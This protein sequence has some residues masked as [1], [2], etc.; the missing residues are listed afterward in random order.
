MDADPHV[1]GW[2][3]T[4]ALLAGA[5]VALGAFGAHG[6]EGR[7]TPSRLDVFDTAVRYQ[8]LHALGLLACA[9]LGRRALAAAPWFLAG[10]VL[11][12]G[13]L[14]ALAAGGPGWWGAVA[15]FG[16]AAMIGGWLVLAW[17]AWRPPNPL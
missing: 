15:P 10:I 5:A 14:Y 8:A 1:R 17:R 2:A 3:A 9:A 7:L 16:G 12:S 13:S 11:F 6:L 4:G